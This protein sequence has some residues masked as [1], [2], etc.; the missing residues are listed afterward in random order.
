V[1]NKMDELTKNFIKQWEDAGWK[2]DDADFD[3]KETEIIQSLIK[4]FRMRTDMTEECKNSAISDIE[5]KAKDIF[6]DLQNQLYEKV[7]QGESLQKFSG[8]FSISYNYFNFGEE[9]GN[10]GLQK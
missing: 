4:S 9:V 10:D 7:S 2:K 8:G 1:K 6:I 3:Y 5:I